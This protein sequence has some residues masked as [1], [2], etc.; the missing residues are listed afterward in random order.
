MPLDPNQVRGIA[1]VHH[2]FLYQH[3]AAAQALVR[4][5]L[6]QL[7][8]LQLVIERDEDLELHSTARS[9]YLQ[10]KARELLQFAEIS[11]AL[12]RLHKVRI[13]HETGQR[14]GACHVGFVLGGSL[15]PE[16]AGRNSSHRATLLGKVRSLATANQVDPASLEATWSSLVWSTPGNVSA[17]LGSIMIRESAE[18]ALR[19]L[20]ADIARINGLAD[21][22]KTSAFA[23][24]TSMHAIA[25]DSLTE[26]PGRAVRPDQVPLLVRTIEERVAKLPSLPTEFVP[27]GLDASVLERGI[28]T[29]IL[30]VSGSGKTT[31]ITWLALAESNVLYAR[32]STNENEAIDTQ[33]VGQLV[34]ALGATSAAPVHL[35]TRR[36]VEAISPL[37]ADR[38]VVI[39]N[40]HLLP[41]SDILEDLFAAA[42]AV[43]S[44][45]LLAGQPLH[46]DGQPTARSIRRLF[47]RAPRLLD[48][49]PWT[50]ANVTSYLARRG[51]PADPIAADTLR[52][53]AGGH[54]LAVT[55][56][57]DL[58]EAAFD[59]DIEEAARSVRRGDAEST[60]RAVTAANFRLLSEHARRVAAVIATLYVSV[61]DADL[62]QFLPPEI[63]Q[64]GVTELREHRY[65]LTSPDSTSRRLN[66]LEVYTPEAALAFRS[67]FSVDEQ[68]AIHELAVALIE[69]R[70][71]R[72]PSPFLIPPLLIHRAYAGHIPEIVD[73]LTSDGPLSTESLARAGVGTP[74]VEALDEILKV[75]TGPED[76]FFILDAILY[77]NEQEDLR[78]NR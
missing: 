44:R 3:V 32:P 70:H 51:R 78:R 43:G 29:A 28:A 65:A 18:L 6:G 61:D 4:H 38:L 64:V 45:I 40:C 14:A 37:L 54:P 73:D 50:T 68:R 27:L 24:V 35:G 55:D 16:L 10:I 5:I 76:R 67:I 9:T 12:L 11:D 63:V 19:D 31:Q 72:M 57:V 48:V 52:T 69:G 33:I 41:K 56:I 7:D 66:L 8:I 36:R 1:R 71:R 77:L 39:D 22:A 62:G 17:D 34:A 26:F 42:L 58:A 46:S 75:A 53:V 20:E 59:G 47:A 15:G 2:G 49:P 74:L 25:A 60:L 30:G 23:L 21:H 13:A